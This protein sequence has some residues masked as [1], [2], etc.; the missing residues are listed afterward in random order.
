ML[1]T[2]AS[3]AKH[4]SVLVVEDEDDIRAAIA[5]ILES[6]GYDVTIATNGRE[7]MEELSDVRYVPRLILLDLMMPEMNGH[8]FLARRQTIPR[9]RNVPVMVLTAVTTD[10]PPGANAL[11]RKP[12]SVEELLEAVRSMLPIAA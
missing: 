12:F 7:A 10:I 1:S 8:E 6:E 5:E 2:M 9:L 11:L 4:S 3:V